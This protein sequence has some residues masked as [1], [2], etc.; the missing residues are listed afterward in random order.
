MKGQNL[1]QQIQQ[2]P[3]SHDMLGFESDVNRLFFIQRRIHV[4]SMPQTLMG[5][6]LK[7]FHTSIVVAASVEEAQEFY[8]A[9]IEEDLA[10]DRILY[11]NAPAIVRFN[12]FPLVVVREKL[13]AWELLLQTHGV[14]VI[15]P[16]YFTPLEYDEPVLCYQQQF[17]PKENHNELNIE[18]YAEADLNSAQVRLEKEGSNIHQLLI[19]RLIPGY[20]ADVLPSY[21]D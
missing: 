21:F 14:L 5:R 3:A 2:N 17:A 1:I 13:I 10:Q 12:E 7:D 9:T 19:S 18:I 11:W 20:V 6:S 15:R 4:K 8:Q 16:G